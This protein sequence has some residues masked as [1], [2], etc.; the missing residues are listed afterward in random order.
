MSLVLPGLMHEI[1]AAVKSAPWK[2]VLLI[3]LVSWDILAHIVL[4][5]RVHSVGHIPWTLCQGVPSSYLH[6]I[7]IL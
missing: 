3:S 4:Y 7:G 6:R 1:L 5:S 2:T